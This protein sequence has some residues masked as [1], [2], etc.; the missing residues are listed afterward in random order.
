[1][2]L[3][4]KRWVWNHLLSP[5]PLAGALVGLDAAVLVFPDPVPESLL[6]EVRVGTLQKLSDAG[7][8]LYLC[9][10]KDTGD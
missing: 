8:V 10:A 1:M 4:I 9:I 7:L 6:L 3:S 2:G 5:S